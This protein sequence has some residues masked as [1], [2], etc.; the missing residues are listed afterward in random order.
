MMKHFSFN[1]R[2]ALLLSFAF[3]MT[4]LCASAATT[5]ISSSPLTGSSSIAVK[6]NLMFIIDD[7]GSM[8]WE[9]L[10]DSVNNNDDKNCYRNYLYNRVYY[11]PTYTYA[12]PVD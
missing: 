7:S 8:G 3:L 5:D 4:S 1:T 10:P 6:P 12:L 9:Y 11:D 2:L